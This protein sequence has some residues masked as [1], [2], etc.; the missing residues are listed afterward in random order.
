[1]KGSDYINASFIDV[2]CWQREMSILHDHMCLPQGYGDKKHAY[3]AA[4]G[5]FTTES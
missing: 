3:I 5:E 1:M 4:Q 2:S